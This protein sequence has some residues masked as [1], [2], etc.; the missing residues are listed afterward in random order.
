MKKAL[1]MALALLFTVSTSSL[2]LAQ[3]TSTPAK[4]MKKTHKKHHT[5]KKKSTGSSTSSSSP[6]PAN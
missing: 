6:A 2:V 1:V 3:S 5:K 4:T